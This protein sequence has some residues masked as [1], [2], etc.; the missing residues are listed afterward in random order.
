[1]RILLG[2]ASVADLSNSKKYRDA[3]GQLERI[4][5]FPSSRKQLQQCRERLSHSHPLLA[6]VVPK[7]L[8]LALEAYAE[9]F[10]ALL[11]AD[12]RAKQILKEKSDLL[13]RL[14]AV[15]KLPQAVQKKALDL[16]NQLQF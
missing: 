13:I 1:M 16:D 11:P 3:V 2:L 10:K 6:R 9:M 12:D 15:L 8:L 5:L 14:S 7:A 4:E